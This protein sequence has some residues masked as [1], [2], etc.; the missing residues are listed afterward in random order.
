MTQ[1]PS[2]E[3]RFA[4]SY[5]RYGKGGYIAAESDRNRTRRKIQLAAAIVLNLV[6]VVMEVWANLSLW[7]QHPVFR[8]L[9]IFY[10]HQSNF[11]ALITSVFFV[12]AGVPKLFGDGRMPHVIKFFRLM[13]TVMLYITFIVVLVGLGPMSILAGGDLFSMYGGPMFVMHLMGPIVSL[14]S[15]VFFEGTPRVGLGDALL[16]VQYNYLYTIVMVI[17]NAVG[18]VEGPYPFLM[19]DTNPVWL[20]IFYAAVMLPGAF[21]VALCGKWLNNGIACR[22]AGETDDL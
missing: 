7:Q 4:N 17:L 6:L 10:T 14:V 1:T 22:L 21:L 13:S 8:D 16:A 5:S 11:I 20:S 9:A 15:F 19:V 2:G 3:G 18:K 12:L